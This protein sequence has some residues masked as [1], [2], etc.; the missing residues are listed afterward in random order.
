MLIIALMYAILAGTFVVGKVALNYSP[1]AF[2]IGVRMLLGGS[3]LLLFYR[4]ALG[5]KLHVARSDVGLLLW[6][7]LFHIYLTYVPEF[8][9][10]QYLSASK[11]IL[12]FSMTPFVT[13]LLAY[14]MYDERLSRW[15]W[16]GMTIAFISMLPVVL[17][18]EAPGELN[19]ELWKLSLPELVLFGTVLSGAY[20]WLKVHKL[21]DRGYSPIFIN[22]TAM[23]IGGVLSLLTAFPIEGLYPVAP[24]AFWP[25]MGSVMLLILMANIIFYNAYGWLIQKYGLTTVAT[26]GF[27]SPIFGGIMGWFFLGEKLTWHYAVSLGGIAYGLRLFYKK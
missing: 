17:L 3:I 4:F 22:G 2:L 15:Q 16:L 5:R 25:F 20:A 12:L 18:Q 19:G 1:P 23:V 7:S 8:W 6:T 11:T 27:L 10:L 9:A 14:F 24:G 21:M 26:V 13:A